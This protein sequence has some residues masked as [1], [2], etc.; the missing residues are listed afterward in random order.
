VE[1]ITKHK[2]RKIETTTEA[3]LIDPQVRLV[4]LFGITQEHTKVC[5]IR[6]ALSNTDHQE[7]RKWH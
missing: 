6:I 4:D 5:D 3:R 2:A 7:I 1:S